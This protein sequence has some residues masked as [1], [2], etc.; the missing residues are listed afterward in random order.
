MVVPPDKTT[1]P[2]LENLLSAST[3]E[4]YWT[5]S[6]VP[7]NV[8]VTLVDLQEGGKEMS[9]VPQIIYPTDRIVPKELKSASIDSHSKKKSL[10]SLV[11]TGSFK[12]KE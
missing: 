10:R 9:G 12:A 4:R 6:Q 7:T 5:D 11:D 8:Q 3:S 2:Y 1:L